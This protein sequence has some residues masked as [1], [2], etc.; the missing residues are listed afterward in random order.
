MQTNLVATFF[1]NTKSNQKYVLVKVNS[2]YVRLQIDT[3][4]D[5][6][7]I[8]QRLWKTIGQPPVTPSRHVAWSPFDDCIP[9]TE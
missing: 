8:S 3:V 6:T 5:I 7:F 9:I 2:H 1:P 4:S